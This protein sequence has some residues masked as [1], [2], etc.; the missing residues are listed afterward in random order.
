MRHQNKEENL[1]PIRAIEARYIAVQMFAMKTTAQAQ[2]SNDK[3]RAP[4]TKAPS[5]IIPTLMKSL[6]LFN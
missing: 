4:A 6:D 2:A 3:S 5:T 1:L